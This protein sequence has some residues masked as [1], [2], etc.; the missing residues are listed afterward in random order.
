VPVRV[1][2]GKSENLPVDMAEHFFGCVSSNFDPA[3]MLRHI[4]KRQGWNTPDFVKVD[5]KTGKNKAQE[6]FELLAIRPVMYKLVEVEDANPRT[7]V[8]A[9][10]EVPAE[11]RGPGRP[12]KRP[13]E[14]SA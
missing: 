9:D 1:P 6:Y 10:P 4:A 11:R 5:P 7:P 2:P 3:V 14:A 12:L 13:Q 8:P